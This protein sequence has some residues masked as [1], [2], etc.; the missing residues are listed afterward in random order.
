[1][2][3]GKSLCRNMYNPK[4]DQKLGELSSCKNEMKFLPTKLNFLIKNDNQQNCGKTAV[5]LTATLAWLQ[6]SYG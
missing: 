4:G 5:P 6:K 1:M 3:E 2:Q